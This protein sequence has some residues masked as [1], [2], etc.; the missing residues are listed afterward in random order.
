MLCR[1]RL[2]HLTAT[3]AR[4]LSSRQTKVSRSGKLMLQPLA[5]RPRLAHVR[6]KAQPLL[7]MP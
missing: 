4:S 6:L 7:A 2:L 3:T 5:L 1:L